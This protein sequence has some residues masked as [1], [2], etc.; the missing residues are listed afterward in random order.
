MNVKYFTETLS[1]V[2]L[3]GNMI[4]VFGEGFVDEVGFRLRIEGWACFRHVEAR[5]L[6]QVKG[7]AYAN[8]WIAL[9]FN[10]LLI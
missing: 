4:G 1:A 3:V 9:P 10:F 8:V 2:Q 5:G 6:F 7:M